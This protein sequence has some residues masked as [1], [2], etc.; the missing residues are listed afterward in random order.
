MTA[1]GYDSYVAQGGDWGSAV[2]TMIGAQDLGGCKAIHTNMPTV[3]P[4]ADLLTDLTPQEQQ[5]IEA[6][7]FYQD[8]DSGYSKQQSTRPQTRRLRPRRLAGRTGGVD[9]R[10]V[11]AMDRLRRPHRERA[12]TRR[13]ARQRLG[14]LVHGDGGIVGAAV[15]GELRQVP[16]RD[17]SR[18]RPAAASTRKEIIRSSR[19][20]AA[21]KYT[22]IRYWN[23]LDRGGH[24]AAFE[25]PELFVSELR[26][27][28]AVLTGDG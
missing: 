10:E 6:A 17:R 22:D 26:A 13:A 20:W 21:S 7:K 9:P 4:T 12:D 8:W 5:A 15:L 3:R 16:R 2:T 27:A 14:V 11:L 1:L 18:C 24:F 19:R 25:Q 23:E 28:F